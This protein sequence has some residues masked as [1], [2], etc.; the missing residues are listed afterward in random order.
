MFLIVIIKAKSGYVKRL[1]LSV[2]Y[3]LTTEMFVIW[4]AGPLK[5]H[6]TVGT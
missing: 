5:L 1:A 4:E 6:A 3:F 2:D